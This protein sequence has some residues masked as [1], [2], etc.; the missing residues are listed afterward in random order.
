MDLSL[1]EYIGKKKPIDTLAL[2]NIRKKEKAEIDPEDLDNELDEYMA[3]APKK[4]VE[5]GCTSYSKFTRIKRQESDNEDVEMPTQGSC[6]DGC[7]KSRT[8]IE[9]NDNKVKSKSQQWRLGANGGSKVNGRVRKNYRNNSGKYV[10]QGSF[11]YKYQ[12]GSNQGV[13]GIVRNQRYH[14]ENPRRSFRPNNNP[15][16]VNVALGPHDLDLIMPQPYTP[17]TVAFPQVY[18]NDIKEFYE[19]LKNKQLAEEPEDD[20]FTVEVDL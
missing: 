3:S 4:E 1:D 17:P 8:K 18:G 19:Y 20:E 14:P 6:N 7:C 10:E 16:T 15:I 5:Q 12:N 2:L 9:Y 11:T 13:S